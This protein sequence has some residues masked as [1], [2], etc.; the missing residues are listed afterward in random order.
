MSSSTL[1]SPPRFPVVN[2]R[3]SALTFDQALTL[4]D[5]WIA[6]RERHY[7]NVCTTHTVLECHDAPEL[8]AVV[9]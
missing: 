9:N 7:V 3:I 4:I 6:R 5:G 2:A 8:A 1:S